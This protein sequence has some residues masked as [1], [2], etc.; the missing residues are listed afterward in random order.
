MNGGVYF[1]FRFVAKLRRVYGEAAI[2]SAT[3]CAAL[4]LDC[5]GDRNHH[6]CFPS[7]SKCAS[8]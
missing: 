4:A 1:A 7:L 8:G 5:W 3:R 2:V 6:C